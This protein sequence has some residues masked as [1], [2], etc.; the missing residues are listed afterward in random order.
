MVTKKGEAKR[1][2]R[3]QLMGS[4][5]LFAVFLCPAYAKPELPEWD[6]KSDRESY[7]LGGG[8]W[9]AGA[10]PDSNDSLENSDQ[11][12]RLANS[13]GAENSNNAGSNPNGGP[14]PLVSGPARGEDL[15]AVSRPPT[16]N[17]GP[18]A[19]KPVVGLRVPTPMLMPLRIEEVY[20]HELPEVEGNLKDDYFALRPVSV[21]GTGGVGE[22]S[23]LVDP[24]QLLTEQKSHD[25]ERFL[26][27]HAE[28][29]E[30]DICLLLFGGDQ[31]IPADISLEQKHQ[32]WFGQD[33]VVTVAYFLEHP[34]L[35]QVVYGQQV[36]Q[37]LPAVVF[38]RIFQ[39]CVRE[40]QVAETAF[41]QV[42][43]FAIELSIRLYWM[44]KLLERQSAGETIAS[45]QESL[46]EPD[47]Q[48][49]A[50]ESEG[51]VVASSNSGAARVTEKL[52]D[53][54]WLLMSLG[55]G[56]LSCL[57]GGGW[58]WWRRDSLAGK[59]VLFPDLEMPSRLGGVYSGGG[60]VGI[61]FDVSANT[62]N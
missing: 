16:I 13:T 33:P 40:A 3:A 50:A 35:T 24:Q 41:D 29:A 49:L 18:I 39:S 30:F 7:P 1:R 4:V 56:F 37:R 55:T 46:S 58:W 36:K 45:T 54:P 26:E 38:D 34:E 51:A 11:T 62:E 5:F 21:G 61:S 14:P 48:E 43:R 12:S 27:Y 52:M 8:L 2:K 19:L 44:A 57:I 59:P 9:P 20:S 25:I 32:E 22:K 53:L 10:L 47:W 17:D 15:V 6:G 31:K 23:F 28:E 60:Y 42:E